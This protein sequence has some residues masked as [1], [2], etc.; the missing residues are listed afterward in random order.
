MEQKTIRLN[1]DLSL[2]YG[3]RTFRAPLAALMMLAAAG[4]LNSESVTLS[5]Y[6]PAPSGV[7]TNMIT[8]GNTYLA[9]DGGAASRVGIGTITPGSKL[10]VAGSLSMGSYSGDAAP[11]NALIVGGRVG[12]GTIAP[13]QAL[14]VVGN[15]NV[16][17]GGGSNGYVKINAL[18]CSL[19]GSVANGTIC[20]AG[21][22]ATFQPGVFTMGTSYN[23]LPAP[24][25][26]T[27]PPALARIYKFVGIDPLTGQQS[28][29][30]MGYTEA[31]RVA[32]CPIGAP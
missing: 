16:Q 29:M 4:D 30:S 20:P 24:F 19:S 17:G 22:Y 26:I 11:A 14:D 3:P 5:T 13:A 28:A 18:G 9:R 10:S 15:V 6:Y 21:Q 31:I 23:N 8:T 1:F 12:V 32:C 2:V 25:L 7:Y 27:P